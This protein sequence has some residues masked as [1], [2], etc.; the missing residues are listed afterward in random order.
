MPVLLRCVLNALPFSVF[1]RADRSCYFV[2]FK[3]PDGKYLRPVST[4]KK[5]ES[6]AM[7][8]AFQMCRDG[9]PQKQRALSV[10]NVF[11]KEKTGSKRP[12][13]KIMFDAL[14]DPA[15]LLSILQT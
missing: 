5:T 8:A 3:G 10:Q 15:N 1:K 14:L 9:I 4:G 12:L 6:E 11:Y 13:S 7:Q 2:S